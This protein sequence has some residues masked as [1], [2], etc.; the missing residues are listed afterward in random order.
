MNRKSLPKAT[1]IYSFR[2]LLEF[3]YGLEWQICTWLRKF[4]AERD[5]AIPFSGPEAAEEELDILALIPENE[6]IRDYEEPLHLMKGMFFTE[7]FKID[8]KKLSQNLVE[9]EHEKPRLR[10]RVKP[11]PLR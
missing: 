3:E 4:L 11:K 10:D 1:V 8:W 6:Y 7:H 5:S 2:N 9:F